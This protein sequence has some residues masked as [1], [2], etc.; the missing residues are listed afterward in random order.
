M[1]EDRK[2]T[3][4]EALIRTIIDTEFTYKRH[5][6]GGIAHPPVVAMYRDYGAGGDH[7]ARRLSKI[8]G[9]KIY[10][11][12]ILDS[13]ANAANVDKELMAEL[14]DKVRHDK[15]VW[16]RGLFT[17]NTAYPENY[18]HHLVN[19]VLGIARSGGIIMGRGAHII[20]S[21][22][23]VFRVRVIG[24]EQRC[25]ERIAKR[26]SMGV[27]S[28]RVKVASINKERGE[29]LW[30]MFHERANDASLF[31][32]IINTDKFD[33]TRAAAELIAIAMD[34]MGFDVPERAREA[35]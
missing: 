15:S 32:L 34:A 9:V 22:R 18:R 11:Q 31:D 16:V 10:D 14:D 1:A 33:S 20:L 19:A 2:P 28:A 5:K 35:E 30:N 27:E 7:I 3:S 25:A 12:E 24:S 26:E 29:F 6:H 4:E 17:T 23:H 21:D 8:L 13:I